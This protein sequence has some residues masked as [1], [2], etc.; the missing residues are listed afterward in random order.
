MSDKQN[1]YGDI[2]SLIDDEES[3]VNSRSARLSPVFQSLGG[4][5]RKK[6]GVLREQEKSKEALDNLAR[7]FEQEKQFLKDQLNKALEESKE[8]DS[9]VLTMPVTKQD[10][11]FQLTKIS[12]ELIYVSPE[13]ERIQEFLDEMSLQ[14]I[15][16]SIIKSGQTEPGMVRPKGDGTYELIKGSR[17]NASCKIA[18]L[19]FLTYVGDVPDADVR[20][21]AE[22]ENKKKDVSAYEKALAFKRQIDNREYSSWSKLALAREI[23]P[24]HLS[25]FKTLSELDSKYVKILSSPSD[26]PLSYGETISTLIKID[27]ESLDSKVD[28]FLQL[29]KSSN[30][31]ELGYPDI[32]QIIKSLKKAVKSK[33][34]K[35]TIKKPVVYKSAV[36]N[37]QLKHTLSSNG[38]TKFE[39]IGA[40]EKQLED[41]L[42]RLM[43]ELKVD[44]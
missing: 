2:D 14:D 10:I 7:E 4:A 20:A 30:I 33:V 19:E 34:K 42:S 28:E 40:T 21:L 43:K 3:T 32:D 16:P 41:V 31:D 37:I 1:K 36:G 29:R 23:S 18:G 12:P 26:M 44:L 13:N 11:T 38:T 8:G 27:K 39:V 35:P 5:N 22:I 24:A 17:R 15:L 25:R 6:S 9:T